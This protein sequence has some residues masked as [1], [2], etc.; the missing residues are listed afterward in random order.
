MSGLRGR[1]L[2]LEEPIQPGRPSQPGPK[3]GVYETS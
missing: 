2:E 1:G 3:A